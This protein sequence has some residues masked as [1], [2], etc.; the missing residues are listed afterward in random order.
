[1]NSPET[2]RTEEKEFPVQTSFD[3]EEVSDKL[4]RIIEEFHIFF[5]QHRS[6]ISL[7]AFD[8][9]EQT[10]ISEYSSIFFVHTTRRAVLIK[11]LLDEI[12]AIFSQQRSK[13]LEIGLVR[14][15]LSKICGDDLS[16]AFCEQWFEASSIL[17]RRQFLKAAQTPLEDYLMVTGEK[18]HYMEQPALSPVLSNDSSYPMFESR[19]S[20][21]LKLKSQI[22]DI[23]DNNVN[24]RV[25]D[26][27]TAFVLNPVLRTKLN[28]LF[29]DAESVSD[30]DIGH[31]VETDIY[32]LNLAGRFLQWLG[33]DL[34]SLL[35]QELDSIFKVPRDRQILCTRAK[36]MILEDVG[37]ACGGITRERV[38]QIEKKYTRKFLSYYSRIRPQYILAAFSN[39]KGYVDTA[40]IDSFYRDLSGI[41]TYL[42]S[43]E[44]HEFQG[45]LWISLNQLKQVRSITWVP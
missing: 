5:L 45:Q 24:A 36:G 11:W 9:N 44:K 35:Y 43:S 34:R 8:N 28:S 32:G 30:I 18:T 42:F 13:K 22:E 27:I 2:Q 7:D 19:A 25:A 15:H 1:M 23:N 10:L 17:T 41:V 4:S 21:N 33:T 20:K 39:N 29:K 31:F 3:R 6:P 16:N 14:S 37:S 26:L 40:E 38:R 12:N